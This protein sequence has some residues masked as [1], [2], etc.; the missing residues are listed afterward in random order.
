MST[1]N[2]VYLLF[3]PLVKLLLVF[4]TRTLF[5]FFV[6]NVFFTMYKGLVYRISRQSEEPSVYQ[7]GL[8]P[9]RSAAL[10]LTSPF[11]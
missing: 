5:Y 11:H 2:I 3:L 1:A 9:H 6:K 10:Y 4:A 8:F 7:E